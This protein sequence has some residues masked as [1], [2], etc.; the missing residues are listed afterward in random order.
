MKSLFLRQYSLLKSTDFHPLEDYLTEIISLL[1]ECPNKLSD[2]ADHFL[3]EQ[4]EKAETIHVHTQRTYSKLS[5]HSVD[6]RPDLVITFRNHTKKH[7]LFIENKLGSGE[8]NQQLTRYADHLNEYRK[9]GYRVHLLYITQ[10]YDPKDG[11]SLFS[12]LNRSE[13]K[14]IQWYQFYAWLREYTNDLYC[15]QVITYMEELRLNKSRRFSPLDIYSIQNARKTLTMMDDCLDGKVTEAFSRLF[16]KPKK[17]PNRAMQLRYDDRYVITHDQSDWKY[18]VC[19]FWINEEEY[20][21]LCVLIEVSPNCSLTE[22][23]LKAMETFG[24][25]NEDWIY[26][27][28][29]DIN[30]WSC[31]YHE[32]SLSSLLIEE[33]HINSIQDYFVGKLEELYKLKDENPNLIW[34]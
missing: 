25:E 15:K 24:K 14:Q 9:R 17:W 21:T 3:D 12:K 16:G 18:V 10:Y 22:E 13:F 32:I 34:K 31:L 6:S 20:P 11:S 19:G 1:F 33:D 26:E 4:L 5:T 23:V 27:E 8:G 29:D 7:V 2:F 28:P 30:G